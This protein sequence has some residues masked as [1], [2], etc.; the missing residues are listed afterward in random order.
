[1]SAP[2]DDHLDRVAYSLRGVLE[3]VA[4]L[5]E[6]NPY[7]EPLIGP[8]EIMSFEIFPELVDDPRFWDRIRR[9][10]R[11]RLERRTE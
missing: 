9:A 7:I 3:V 6:L 11:A 1:M 10:A 5:D 2:S 4:K 8:P